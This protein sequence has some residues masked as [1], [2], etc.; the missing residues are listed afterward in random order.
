MAKHGTPKTLEQA[1][2]NALHEM[3]ESETSLGQTPAQLIRM[4]VKDFLAHKFGA[5]MLQS[6][7]RLEHSLRNLFDLIIE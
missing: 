6:D 4:H 1:I 3:S 2:K 5:V 7:E